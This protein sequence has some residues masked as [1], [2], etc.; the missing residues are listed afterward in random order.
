MKNVNKKLEERL[1]ILKENTKEK[2]QG[3]ARNFVETLMTYDSND[4]EKKGLEAL[5]KLVKG[6]A[7]NVLFNAG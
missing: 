6:E 5:R 4:K 7:E 1:Q 3:V 2:C